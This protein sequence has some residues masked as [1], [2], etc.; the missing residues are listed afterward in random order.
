MVNVSVDGELVVGGRGVTLGKCAVH[1]VKSGVVMHN[2][3]QYPHPPSL[4]LP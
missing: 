1:V 3:I 4:P 2:C